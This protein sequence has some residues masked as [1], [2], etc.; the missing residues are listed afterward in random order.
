[1]IPQSVIPGFNSVTHR[2]YLITT[3]SE[4]LYARDISTL[5]TAPL[6]QICPDVLALLHFYLS[7]HSEIIHIMGDYWLAKIMQ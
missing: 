3:T 5:E 6:A 2:Q 1:M 7:V 4:S